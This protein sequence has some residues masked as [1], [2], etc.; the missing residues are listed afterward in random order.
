MSKLTRVNLYDIDEDNIVHHGNEDG[1]I[2]DYLQHNHTQHLAPPIDSEYFASIFSRRSKVNVNQGARDIDYSH[3]ESQ[4][5]Y[6][7]FR[8][9]LVV[10]LGEYG[11]V[12]QVCDDGS[13]P[14]VTVVN[15]TE[16]T[17]H[18]KQIQNRVDQE[19][20]NWLRIE[21]RLR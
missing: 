12:A 3:E 20:K 6:K 7:F 21:L 14:Q 19:T 8:D 5:T 2:V 4:L 18:G 15:H 10:V 11:H 9:A 1:C 17:T 16:S 13:T